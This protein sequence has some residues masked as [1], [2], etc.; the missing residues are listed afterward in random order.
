MVRTGSHAAFP[1][2]AAS[3]DS[4]PCARVRWLAVLCLT[5][6]HFAFTTV[7][8][9]SWKRFGVFEPVVLPRRDVYKL[10]LAAFG[11]IATMNLSLA[12]NS[13]GVYQVSVYTAAKCLWRLHPSPLPPNLRR[14]PT[15]IRRR[16]ETSGSEYEYGV[17]VM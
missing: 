17:G 8:L 5:A 12:T 1:G 4:V 15:Q 16:K 14:L 3:S 6:C 2:S 11:S 10:S 13:I 9:E 7:M